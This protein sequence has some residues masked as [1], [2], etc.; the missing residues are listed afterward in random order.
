MPSGQALHDNAVERAERLAHGEW[1]NRRPA[2]A[3]G[4]PSPTAHLLGVRGD[5]LHDGPDI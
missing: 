5:R 1:L 2:C 4:N 3:D